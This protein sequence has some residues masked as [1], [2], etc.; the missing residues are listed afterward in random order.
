MWGNR[1]RSGEKKEKRR[2]HR[3]KFCIFIPP[4]SLTATP[5]CSIPLRSLF[6][7]CYARNKLSQRTNLSHLCL[8]FAEGS[9][10][11]LK[12]PFCSYD[13]RG[14]IL[15]FHFFLYDTIR[16][17]CSMPPLNEALINFSAVILEIF[18]LLSRQC[19]LFFILHETLYRNGD[20]LDAL[21]AGSDEIFRCEV[22]IK[23]GGNVCM[24]ETYF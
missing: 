21:D 3:G 23:Y 19:F 18:H 5:L 2:F 1:E 20:D 22:E 16:F 13:S 17:L 6:M 14:I 12:K 8:A 7:G 4:Q 9:Q 10:A 11:L 15:H 24:Y